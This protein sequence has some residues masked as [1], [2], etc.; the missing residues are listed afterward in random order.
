MAG[1]LLS[2]ASLSA[3]EDLSAVMEWLVSK[4]GKREMEQLRP[5]HGLWCKTQSGV[6]DDGQMPPLIPVQQLFTGRHFEQEIVLLCVRWYLSYKLSYRDLVATMGERGF[7]VAHTT[8]P[9]WVQNSTPEFGLYRAVDKGG[10]EG[11]F[12]VGRKREV[13]RQLPRLCGE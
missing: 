2:S 3:T 7:T 4:G 12:Y 10:K 1:I 5:V 13:E 11:D 8:I 9:R 6:S